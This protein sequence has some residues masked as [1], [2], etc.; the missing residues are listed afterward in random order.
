MKARPARADSSWLKNGVSSVAD[1]EGK[2]LTE[3][4]GFQAGVSFDGN[5]PLVDYVDT[6][7]K[8]YSQ[9]LADGVSGTYKGMT[10]TYTGDG[11]RFHAVGETGAWNW[12]MGS[13]LQWLDGAAGRQLIFNRR[14]GDASARY[15][16]FG[17]T[18]VDADSG[19]Q[20]HLP[21][22]VYVVAPNSRYALCVDYRRLYV[23]HETI[24]Y[25]Q[26]GAPFE[27]PLAPDDDGIHWMD[28]ATGRCRLALA[29]GCV[30][31]PGSPATVF[32]VVTMPP[33]HLM[34]NGYFTA[35]RGPCLLQQFCRNH[36]TQHGLCFAPAH[37]VA[38]PP[39]RTL[40]DRPFRLV[41]GQQQ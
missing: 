18:I 25:A 14:S 35:K 1:V 39:Q 3:A 11:D 24:G 36:G 26:S 40:L 38:Q 8:T 7:G 21:L 41:P 29:F 27:L 2:L 13:Q 32:F 37:P 19:E 20:R 6:A 34:Q 9:D 4:Y 10:F 12:Q 17:A 5:P 23:T 22:P 28:L 16:G 30:A 31:M 15:P 33:P